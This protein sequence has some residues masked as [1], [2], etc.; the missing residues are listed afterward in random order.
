MA[1]TLPSELAW[2]IDPDGF[3]FTGSAREQLAFLV[4]YAVLAPSGHN[5]QPWRFILSDTHVDVV[6]DTSRAL[7]MV[8]P[9]DREMIMSCAAA[10]ETLLAALHAFGLSGTLMPQPLPPVPDIIARVTLLPKPASGGIDRQMLDAIANRR[11]VRRAYAETTV[12]A[13]VQSLMRAAARPFGVELSLFDGMEMRDAVAELVVDADH[14]QF[15][16]PA[17][18]D[19]LASWMHPLTSPAGDGLAGPGFGFPDWATRAAA[20]LFRMFDLGSAVARMDKPNVLGAPLLG[21]FSTPGD[22]RGEWIATG[23]ALASVL[24]TLTMHGLVNAFLNQPIEVTS[25]R[26]KLAQLAAPG[27]TPQLLS[28][29]GYLKE[30]VAMPPHAARRPLDAVLI[31]A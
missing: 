6:A 7:H 26:P 2:S 5:T 8:D 20:T 4:R 19:E 30:G 14:V 17:F 16:S 22:T 11:T 3:P 28:R 15:S 1:E 27:R 29:F 18:R 23:R 10:A 24:H 13:E 25:I 12:P 9:H 21:V 31:A